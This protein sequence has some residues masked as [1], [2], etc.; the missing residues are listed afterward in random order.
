MAGMFLKVKFRVKV[1]SCARALWVEVTLSGPL[2][3]RCR[4]LRPG[5][6]FWPSCSRHYWSKFSLQVRFAGS[7]KCQDKSSLTICQTGLKHTSGTQEEEFLMCST[8]RKTLLFGCIDNLVESETFECNATFLT[9]P[10]KD[11]LPILTSRLLSTMSRSSSCWNP[12]E[13][14]LRQTFCLRA[15]CTRVV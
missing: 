14:V 5:E 12:A 11:G 2:W 13:K 6:Y 7:L 9:P 3:G 10:L 4:N 15:L 1:S 8:E